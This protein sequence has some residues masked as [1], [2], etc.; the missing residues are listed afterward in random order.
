MSDADADSFEDELTTF[1]NHRPTI[2]GERPKS[3]LHR[4][5]HNRDTVWLGQLRHNRA[6]KIAKG[7][8]K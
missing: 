2:F 3:V 4:T 8:T 6:Q 5:T 7:P 1:Q